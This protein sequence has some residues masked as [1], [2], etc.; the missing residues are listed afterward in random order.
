MVLA[1]VGKV[2]QLLEKLRAGVPVE[3]IDDSS[4]SSYYKALEIYKPEA[5]AILK[6]TNDDIKEANSH[7]AATIKELDECKSELSTVRQALV[8]EKKDLEETRIKKPV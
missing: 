1:M 5:D 2:D 8:T 3:E 4:K 7:K 6:K